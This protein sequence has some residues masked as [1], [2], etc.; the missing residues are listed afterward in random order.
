[1]DC[2]GEGINGYSQIVGRCGLNNPIRTPVLFM[3]HTTADES[4]ENLVFDGDLSSIS[5]DGWIGGISDQSDIHQGAF[6]ISPTR[7]LFNLRGASGA[8]ALSA[9]VLAVTYHGWSAGFDFENG[10]LCPLAVAW[11]GAPQQ[12]FP[13]YRLGVC[14]R[15][16]GLTDD[17]FV[18]GT[19][20]NAAQDDSSQFAFLWSPNN[21]L[22]RLP[23]HFSPGE[24]SAARA[25]SAQHHILGSITSGGAAHTV[26]WNVPMPGL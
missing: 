4:P 6:L 11:L 19:G 5:N 24:T 23:G 7:E 13:E 15:S 3:W 9:G 17:W 10:G 14:G 16:T 22:R 20:T 8:L 18:T 26:I 21:G 1:V 2:I 12:V 25:I